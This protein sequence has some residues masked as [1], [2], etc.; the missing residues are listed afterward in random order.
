VARWLSFS[1]AADELHLTQPAISRQIKGLEDELGTALF[2]RGTRRVELS[3]AGSALRAV[4]APLLDQ[5][6]RAVRDIRHRRSRSQVSLSTFA[7]F[8]TLWLLPRLTAWQQTTQPAFDIRISTTDRLVDLDD[9]EID[10]LL[11]Y[12]LP[13]AA[14]PIG[15][16]LF[17]EVLTPVASARLLEQAASGQQPPL[18]R[19][20]DL[21]GHVLL[22]EDD[23]HIAGAYRLSWRRWLTEQRLPALEPRRW[24]FLNYTHQQVQAALAGQGIALARLSLVHDLIER[25]ELVE[26]FDGRCRMAS[27]GSYYLIEV[28][29]TGGRA[30]VRDCTAWIRHE[31][32]LTRGALGEDDPPRP[33][34][35]VLRSTG[36]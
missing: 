25:G 7:S 28:P 35:A 8:A 24:L 22:E 16:K 36:A 3:S 5:F 32:A 34:D 20:P 31:A 18:A 30:E 17:G 27:T 9:P 11:R 12:C 21:A 33:A 1:A 19:P 15:E 4:V 29:H 26:L 6:D 2:F 14:P 10:V 23:T 13:E